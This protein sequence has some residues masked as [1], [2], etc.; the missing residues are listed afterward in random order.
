MQKKEQD[1]SY[2]VVY[3]S[4]NSTEAATPTT[5]KIVNGILYFK[6]AK[7][8]EAAQLTGGE[9]NV[10]YGSDYIKYIHATPITSN[11]TTVYEYIEYPQ[12]VINSLEASPGYSPYYSATPPS[13]NLYQTQITRSSTG[14]YKLTFFNDGTD[15]VNGESKSVSAKL[16]TNFSG[17]RIRLYGLVGP[18]Y[19]KVRIRIIKK[20]INDSDI[21]TVVLDWVEIDCYS[22]NQS[23]S[24]IFQKNDLDYVE[25]NLELE[26]LKDKNILST[27]SSVT[28]TKTAF[29]RNFNFTLGNQ[30]INPNL[31][32]K[33]I[34]GI[35]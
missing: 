3:E 8:H 34:G 31:S 14:Y 25:Y 16:I 13:I 21:E 6:A 23:E 30:I 27:T 11:S 1:H 9:Y 22:P 2:I 15:W 5:S 17:P 10:Y 12:T 28:I 4:F 18:G 19:G 33:S 20:R 35:K 26:V 7:D 32:F 24:I 29:L